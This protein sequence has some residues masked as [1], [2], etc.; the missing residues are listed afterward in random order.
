MSKLRTFRKY[1]NG[2]W[3][4]ASMDE[5]V[6]GDIVLVEDVFNCYY[7]VAKEM[8]HFEYEPDDYRNAIDVDLFELTPDIKPFWMNLNPD[9]KHVATIQQEIANNGGQCCCVVKSKQSEDTICPC[10][11]Y[12]ETRICICQ[13]YIDE[14]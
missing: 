6:A 8:H 4:L 11:A 9:A 12:Q 13:L 5:I 14:E 7:K 3:E 10:K 2:A 1:T